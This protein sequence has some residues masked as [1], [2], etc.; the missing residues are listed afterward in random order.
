MRA[1]TPADV[2]GPQIFVYGRLIYALEGAKA[3]S[4]FVASWGIAL[5]IENASGFQ[6]VLTG[7]IKAAVIAALLEPLV[8]PPLTWFEQHVDFLSVYASF[9]LTTASSRWARI[10]EGVRHYACARPAPPRR[11]C[12]HAL[13]GHP[14]PHALLLR[15]VVS[16]ARCGAD[17]VEG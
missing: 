6:E 11:A 13:D 12:A 1:P 4:S 3:E 9:T 2:A 5:G 10:R 16:A 8:V 17:H 14:A 15:C 7:A